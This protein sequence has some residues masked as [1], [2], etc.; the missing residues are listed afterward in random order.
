MARRL[1]NWER[2]ERE[3]EKEYKRVT[4]ELE[5]DERIAQKNLET[6]NRQLGV[7]ENELAVAQDEIDFT[8]LSFLHA[9]GSPIHLAKKHYTAKLKKNKYRKKTFKK[10]AFKA[11]IY[12]TK[13]YNAKSY[14]TTSSVFQR[15]RYVILLTVAITLLGVNLWPGKNPPDIVAWLFFF[16]P[17]LFKLYL[18]KIKP[19]INMKRHEAQ[20][21]KE[22]ELH[23]K[24]ELE[25]KSK[26]EV[27]VGLTEYR[28]NEQELEKE[29]EHLHNEAE[30]ETK[31]DKIENKRINNLKK[32]KEGE[33]VAISKV[34]ETLYPL[35]FSDSKLLAVTK[36][37]A[38]FHL[39][40][41]TEL[42]VLLKI[43]S[44]ELAIPSEKLVLAQRGKEL[45]GKVIPERQ[46]KKKYNEFI[47]SLALGYCRETIYAYPFFDKLFIE[48]YTI[49]PSP[50][51]GKDI[52]EIR[53]KVEVKIPILLELNLDK[54]DSVDALNNFEFEFQSEIKKASK[55]LES[56]VDRK[57][58]NW[59][60]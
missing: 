3:R 25:K 17:Y 21:L 55:W 54:A 11:P 50:Q 31:Y 32:A 19:R 34:I 35:E 23:E 53:L 44:Y 42:I 13:K 56:S 10:K 37:R 40:T 26:H 14:E 24:K 20:A 8:H 39:K 52:D 4:R 46:R 60:N 1:T 15:P 48:I 30:Q 59:V 22:L 9:N 41:A 45:K 7:L 38:G 43:P 6:S 51:T 49:V 28:F 18:D 58:I 5:R 16:G 29:K 33:I 47:A 27:E 2:A 12:R 36:V 57:S